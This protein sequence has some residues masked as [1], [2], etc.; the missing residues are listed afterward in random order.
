MHMPYTIHPKIPEIRYRA[1]SLV[2][3]RGW[4]TR[5]VARHFGHDHSTVVRW[6]R[7]K[8][9]Y[10]PLGQLVIPTLSCRPESHPRELSDRVVQKIMELRRER[11]QCAEILHHRLVKEGILVSLSSVKRTLR[12]H[13]LS[14]YSKWKK[15]HVY[16]PRP[17][18]QKPGSLIQIDTIWD[19][20][21]RDR[22]YAYTLLDVC[23]RWAFSVP[24]S[25]INT[26]SSLAFVRA[27]QVAS[28]FPFRVL[29]SD[30][31]QEFSLWFT[32]RLR[33]RDLVHRHSR[34]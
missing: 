16:P 26:H 17:L 19:G 12:R 5:A 10:N 1:F 32:Q 14:R 21:T 29:Q 28:P 34:V 3:D 13:G 18:A 9:E 15:W 24:A 22:L 25:R 4:S 20:Q 30:H 6:L 23:S 8:P 27:A 31:G 33:E 11:N 2:K 7:R